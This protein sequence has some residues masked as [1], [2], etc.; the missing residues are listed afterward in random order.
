MKQYQ[1]TADYIKS[2]TNITPRIGIVLGSGLG[3]LAN[4][5]QKDID[6]SYQNLPNFP[7]STVVGHDGKLIIGHI[8]SVPVIAMQGRFHYYEGYSMDQVTFPIRVMKFLGIESLFVSNAAGGLNPD[9]KTGDL[10]VIEDHINFFPENPLRGENNEQLGP[11]FPDMSKV[12]DKEL[13][14]LAFK[15]AKK[16]GIHLRSGVYI[17][18]QGPTLE[19]PSEY[20]MFRIL[21]ADA[22]GMS[23]VPEIIVARHMNIKCFGVS[24]ITNESENADPDAITTHEEVNTNAAAAEPTLTKLFIAMI[25]SLS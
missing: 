22:T 1:E 10:M 15:I 24:V 3:S 5:I 2:K 21:G 13:R 19:T 20:K 11:R 17:G 8:G 9:F 6:I 14:Q 16:S 18:S 4:S 25:S 12:Y 23:T 7:V